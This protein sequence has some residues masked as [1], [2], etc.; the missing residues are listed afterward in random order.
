MSAEQREP[1][2]RAPGIVLALIGLFA[3]I[4]M[5][6]QLLDPYD[7]ALVIAT[8]AF[9]PARF[10]DTADQWPGAPWAGPVSLVSHMLLHGDGVH[11]LVNSAWLLAVGAPIAQRMSAFSFVVFMSVCAVGGAAFFYVVNIGLDVP[12]IGASGA[13]S[14]LMAAVFRLIFASEGAVG[15]QRLRDNPMSAPR[16]SLSGTMTSRSAVTAILVWVAVNFLF[17]F[18]LGG[19]SAPGGIAWEAHLGG[20][21]T[22]LVLFGLFD[23]GRE[24]H[25]S[26]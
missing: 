13:I 18:G 17:A 26:S 21:F 14:G 6:R 11:L 2:I 9:V 4:H 24:V 10:T 8:F 5:L 3:A 23:R 22:G 19:L 15:F 20:F 25:V 1:I 7:D 12:M 16:L